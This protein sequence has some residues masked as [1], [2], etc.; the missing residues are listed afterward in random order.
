MLVAAANGRADDLKAHLHILKAHL[1]IVL[2]CRR[3]LKILKRVGELQMLHRCLRASAICIFAALVGCSGPVDS[4]AKAVSEWVIG[5][6]GKLTAIGRTVEFKAVEDIPSDTFGIKNIDL[7]GTKVTNADL[8]QLTEL[9]GLKYLGLHSTGI[10]DDAMGHI[11][12]IRTLERLELSNT[13]ITNKGIQR[14][15]ELPNLKQLFIS[16]TAVTEKGVE[17]LKTQLK[18]CQIQY[19]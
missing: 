13:S 3:F 11:V 4:D 18:G 12:K 1:H 8:E 14:L 6:G 7:H 5:A 15:A 16:N 19:F 9:V 17:S 10:T 2:C